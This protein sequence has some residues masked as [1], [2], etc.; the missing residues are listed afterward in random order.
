MPSCST[1]AGSAVTIFI[2]GSRAPITPV[3]AVSTA[4]FC[5]PSASATAVRITETSSSPAGP[6]SALALPELA[7][8]ARIPSA[9]TRAARVLHRRGGRLVDGEDAGAAAG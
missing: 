8:T 6:V 1:S 7:S 4:R 3:E 2:A 5:T 9:G